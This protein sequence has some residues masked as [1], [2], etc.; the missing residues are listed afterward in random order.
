VSMVALHVVYFIALALAASR[1]PAGLAGAGRMPFL[2]TI[3]VAAMGFVGYNMRWTHSL[4]PGA[5]APAIAALAGLA[6]WGCLRIRPREVGTRPSA[7]GPGRAG[8]RAARAAADGRFR[9]PVASPDFGGMSLREVMTPKAMIAGVESGAS[10]SDAVQAALSSGHS[11]L[12]VFE[13][14]LDHIVGVIDVHGLLSA[15]GRSRGIARLMRPAMFVPECKRCFGMLERFLREREQFAV[16]LD[17]FGGT[18]GVITVEDL[19]DELVGEMAD[20][21]ER[22]DAPVRR[23]PDGGYRVPG[24]MK[25]DELN[26]RLALNI[27]EGDYETVS[28]YVLEKLGRVPARGEKVSLE[29][30]TLEIAASTA[31]RIVAVKIVKRVGERGR[32]SVD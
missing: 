32:P 14:D 26:S 1:V 10:T 16:V 9:M 19:L 20:E 2:G 11:R 15:F 31:R 12:V 8:E 22:E 28:G 27:P 25:I 21:H 13:G 7:A 18:A 23:M 24:H 29:D 6:V 17:E 5:V 3:A 4:P 30:A